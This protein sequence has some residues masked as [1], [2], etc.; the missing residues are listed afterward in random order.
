M[1]PDLE[2]DDYLASA[3]QDN[4]PAI[5]ELREAC[6]QFLPGF[7]EIFRYDIPAYERN[8]EVEIAWASHKDHLSFYVLRT[9]VLNAH[10][11]RLEGLSIDE[12]CIRYQHPDQ[13][14]MD[15]VRSIL[16]M[17]ALTSGEIC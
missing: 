2:V 6:L 17:N 5:T 15:V 7:R 13:I 9:D 8:D 16:Q 14:D 3:P 11:P 1:M 12:G 10:V 4:H